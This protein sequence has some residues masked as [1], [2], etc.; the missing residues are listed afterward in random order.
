MG[1]KKYQMGFIEMP[2][3]KLVKADWN[4]KTEDENK[5]AKL[6]ENIKRNGQIENIIIRE[7]DTG[8]FEVVN[9][10][11]RL[12][13]LSD[14]K[15]KG[16][17]CYNLGKISQ[18]QAIRIAIETNETKFDTDSVTLAERI[19]ELTE[20][21]NIEE[22]V[23]TLPYTKQE[24]ENFSKLTNFDWEEYTE[25]QTID[26]LDDVE[27]DKKITVNV[28]NET[29][30]RWLELKDRFQGIIG[31]DNE[32]KVFEFAIIEALNIPLKSLE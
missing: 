15:Q 4:Y 5:Q 11:H 30:K 31:Y 23:E 10:N 9:G 16:V 8:Y 12:S 32:S 22:L 1:K 7:L 18:A 27:F 20:D 29:F 19:K 14:L 24:I 3:E 21:F 25:N 2:L 17:H 28:T 6:K 26:T 13:V